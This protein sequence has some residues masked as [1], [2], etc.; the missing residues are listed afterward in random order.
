MAL[1]LITLPCLK[2]NYAFLVH[3]P[4]T[5]ETALVDVPEAAPILAELARR[6]WTL[7]DILL[8]HHHWDHIDGLPDLLAGLAAPPR[9]WGAAADAHRLPPL[10]HAVAEGDQPVICGEA[11]LAISLFIFPSRIFYFPGTA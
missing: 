3:N 5:H 1:D 8:T 7:T 11:P 10:D 4:D 9:I 6:D 2:D